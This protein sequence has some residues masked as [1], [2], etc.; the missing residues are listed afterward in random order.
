LQRFPT[1]HRLAV[2]QFLALLA[3]DL[4]FVG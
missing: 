2:R 4:G 1:S 3:A